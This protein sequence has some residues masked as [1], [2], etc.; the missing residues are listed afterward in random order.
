MKTMSYAESR[1]RY[2]EVLDSVTNDRE[3]VIITRAGHDP[4]V[5][6]KPEALKTRLLRILVPAN[7]RRASP[8]LQDRRQRRAHRSLPLSL[9]V[10]LLC[11]IRAG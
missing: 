3:E 8:R 7:D 6:G 4:V 5:I 11:P 2:A 10:A 9:R 1:V